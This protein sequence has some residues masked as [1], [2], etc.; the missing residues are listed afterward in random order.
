MGLNM[1]EQIVD[2]KEGDVGTFQSN[3]GGFAIDGSEVE[4]VELKTH[5][6]SGEFYDLWPGGIS[7]RLRLVHDWR[8]TWCRLSEFVPAK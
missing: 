5:E 4:I 7:V 8:E 3:E 2:L 1:S 6:E